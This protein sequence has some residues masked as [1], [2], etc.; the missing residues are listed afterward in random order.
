[1]IFVTHPTNTDREILFYCSDFRIGSCELTQVSVDNKVL[2]QFSCNYIDLSV[3]ALF[4]A[5]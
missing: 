5:D 2:L 1:M 4:S 3:T